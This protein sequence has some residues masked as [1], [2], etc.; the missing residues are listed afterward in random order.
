MEKKFNP[1]YPTKGKKVG[2]FFLGLIGVVVV[3]GA[4]IYAGTVLASTSA[5][6][7]SLFPSLG[8]AFYAGVI[9]W[10]AIKRRNF[11]IWG[12]VTALAV[13]IILFLLLFGYCLLAMSGAQ[14]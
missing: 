4:I 2:D 6:A 7:T 9:V 10:A 3:E 14:F 11:V 1:N 5:G 13:P 12:V 8:I